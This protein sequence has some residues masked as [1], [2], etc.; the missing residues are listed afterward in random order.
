[1][2]FYITCILAGYGIGLPI[3]GFGA[4]ELIEHD[5]DFIY[6]FSGGGLYN[7]GGGVL[8]AGG[9]IGAVMLLRKS[10]LLGGLKKRLAAVGRM[11]FTNYLMHSGISTTIVYGYGFGLFGRIGR[12]DLMGFVLGIWI[13][14]LTVSPIWLQHFRFGP[15]EWLWRTLTYGS[16]QPLRLKGW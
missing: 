4:R 7:Y 1:M 3:V 12:F 16:V 6:L 15:L 14:Q 5:F 10:D 9:H 11:A 8:V 13:L 2:R